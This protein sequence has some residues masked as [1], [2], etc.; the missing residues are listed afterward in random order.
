[1]NSVVLFQGQGSYRTEYIRGLLE[2]KKELKTLWETANKILGW[3]VLDLL[4]HT[5]NVG[6][7]PTNQAQTIIFMMEYTAWYAYKDELTEAPKYLAG[8]SL[9]ELVALAAAEVYS[10]ED[11]LKLV[12]VRGNIMQQSSNGVNQGMLALQDCSAQQAQILCEEAR[13][14]T[15]KEVYCA[16]YNSPTQ[17]IVSGENEALDYCEKT[18]DLHVQKLQVTKAFHTPL[19]RE[20]AE[21]FKEYLNK[22]SFSYPRIPVISNVTARPYQA[23]WTIGDLLYKQIF[24]PVRWAESM[25]YFKEKGI[26]VF[27]QATNS[28]LF[29]NMDI[30]YNENLQWGSLEDL[31]SNKL[32]DFDKLYYAAIENELYSEELCGE[33]LKKMLSYPWKQA[34]ENDISKAK[35]AYKRVLQISSIKDYT[36]IQ[37]E[38]CVKKLAEVLVL[39]GMGVEEAKLNCTEILNKYGVYI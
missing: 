20:A 30:D 36:R 26:M 7:L 28:T 19:M 11:A 1:M 31:A 14:K 17:I 6:K 23:T 33:I 9:G 5:E 16:N 32:Y 3:S 24:S 10:F 25:M 29:R 18:T 22:V 27:L 35:E 8:H 39:K 38:Q 37:I 15:G 21:Q 12:Q 34:E 2:K 13:K 4:Y